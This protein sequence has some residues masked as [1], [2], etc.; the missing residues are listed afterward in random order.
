MVRGGSGDG[1]AAGFTAE[2]ADVVLREA[3]T[4]VGFDPTGA[5]L[6]RLG[7]NAGYS[8]ADR[9]VVVRIAAD[10]G[11]PPG[12]ERAVRVARWLG[13]ERFPVN[14]VPPGVPQPMADFG[15]VGATGA[16]Q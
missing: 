13:E 6:L 10:P 14:R 1:G 16:D 4:S 7:S 8:S 5:R 12:M 9:P 11:G 3:C 2:A 15:P